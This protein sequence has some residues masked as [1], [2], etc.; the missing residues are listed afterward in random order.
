MSGAGSACT[1]SGMLSST[2][3]RSRSA[4][5]YARAVSAAADAPEWMRSGIAPRVAAMPAWSTRKFER[6]AAAGAS[7]AISSSGVR[8]LAA[9]VSPVSALVKPGPWCTLH[10]P[11]RVRHARVAVGHRDRAALVAGVVE[12][13]PGGVQRLGGEEVAAAED[14]ERVADPE[15]G[16]RAPDRLGRVHA[17]TS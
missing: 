1:S 3:R 4:R 14:A 12:R 13:A 7:P 5:R 15:R 17:P 10:T 8:L 11:T 16:E 2:G 6:I 9:S